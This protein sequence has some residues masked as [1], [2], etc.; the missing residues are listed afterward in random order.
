[1]LQKRNA[2]IVD[3]FFAVFPV[4]REAEIE[5]ERPKA[6][7]ARL[8]NWLTTFSK[9]PDA[10]ATKRSTELHQ[11]F[12]GL[13]SHGDNAI[14]KLALACLLR[15]K[16]KGLQAFE[17]QLFD[18]LEQSHFRDALLAL[19]LS[20]EADVIQPD[21]RGEVVPVV[22]RILFGVATS[23]QL[24]SVASARRV[25]ILT[26]LR[27]CS[28]EE[29]DTLVDLMLAPFEDLASEPWA[30]RGPKASMKRQVG[31]LYFLADVLK[32]LC[33]AVDPKRLPPLCAAALGMLRAGQGST[34]PQARKVRVL[35]MQ[36]FADFFRLPDTVSFDPSPFLTPAF[37]AL[38]SPR[39][40]SLANETAQSPSAL[41]DLAMVWAGKRGTIGILVDYDA[42]LLP[43]IYATL[44]V[45]NVK[46]VVVSRIID[47]LQLILAQAAEDTSI[48]DKVVRPYVSLTVSYLAT[49]LGKRAPDQGAKDDLGKKEIALV[50]ALAPYI[51]EKE[52][53]ASFVELLLPLL[54]KPNK[55]VP[56]N[57]KVDLLKILTELFP[58]AAVRENEAIGRKCEAT[59]GALFAYVRSRPGRVQLVEA[60]T[61]LAEEDDEMRE[62]ATIL[63]ELN[64][65]S[66]RRLDE[67]DFDRRL[68]AFATLN[69]QRFRTLSPR[70]WTPLLHNAFSF[71]QDV[72]ELSMRSNASLTL[73]RF[74]EV[75][76]T[77]EA[78][79]VVITVLLP[80]LHS[81]LRS[82]EET[83]RVEVLNVWANAV[84]AIEGVPLFDE[85]RGLLVGGDVEANVFTNILH[86][87][88]H[89]RVRAMRRL[90]EEAEAKRVSSR[91][92]AD[93]WVPLLSYF[94]D[95]T[96][97]ADLANEA[98]LSIGRLSGCLNWSVYYRLLQ[99][100]LKL[101]STSAPT[102][103][104]HVRT[105]VALLKGF[106]FDLTNEA[107]GEGKRILEIVRKRL[108]PRLIKFLEH[109]VDNEEEV[110]IP[111]AEGIAAL[112][113]HLPEGDRRADASILMTSLSQILRSKSQD[114]RDQARSTLCGI[115]VSLGPS[116][117]AIVGRDL[118]GA[119]QRGPQVHV[120]AFTLHAVLVR[121]L[122]MA[123]PEDVDAA[124]EYVMPV[125]ADDLFGAPAKEREADDFRRQSTCVFALSKSEPL[126][127]QIQL[128]GSQVEQ[129]SRLLPTAKRRRRPNFLRP[130]PLPSPRR[131][132]AY[133]SAQDDARGRRGAI[134]HHSGHPSQLAH[135][136]LCPPF[137]LQ[138]THL[139]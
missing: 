98:V 68:T 111:V 110:R 42:A 138:F 37:A 72:E 125:V 82:K 135:R 114:V 35:G 85:M 30:E 47:L 124:L 20:S 103:K 16:S 89:R 52:Q 133:R 70:Q 17:S 118:K 26:S 130:H 134:S 12:L 55:S 56:E 105:S 49:L 46:P 126:L 23:R 18:L 63:R 27:S 25:A 39:L 93:I 106:H 50:A 21:Y 129:E 80:G 5:G 45:S 120:L 33:L 59:L 67:P 77:P 65:F 54:A 11:A 58:V 32:H 73:R 13:L 61:R 7:A 76:S 101:A 31:F 95:G 78:K 96:A 121:L 1:M 2:V 132:D 4:L 88:H 43:A 116:Y 19:S 60:F 97:T 15:W 108:L 41:L 34:A 113:Q 102:Q 107:D 81:T 84:G 91:T 100:R 48:A 69:E 127:N 6:A 71:I 24:K 112:V 40:P 90:A 3:L 131:H 83:V 122:P 22:V 29:L 92:L 75:A 66:A 79:E 104:L 94:L 53:A 14:Q 74:A 119:L 64:A 38:I 123:T 9:L 28:G 136:Y 36:A 10:K 117:L 51:V 57:V 137:P 99:E 115:A 87:Q 62:V 139:A 8:A 86:I 109:R 44:V 128:P